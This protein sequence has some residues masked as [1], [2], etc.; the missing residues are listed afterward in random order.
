[1]STRASRRATGA[2]PH[3]RPLESIR[4]FAMKYDFERCR[5]AV[6]PGLRGPHRESPRGRLRSSR[7]LNE[8][9][10]RPRRPEAVRR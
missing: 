3:E 9:A 5:A 8:R 6:K 10:G 4:R 2:N 1:M 7:D